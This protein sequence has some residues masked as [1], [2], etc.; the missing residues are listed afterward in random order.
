M[1][2]I[3]EN[4]AVRE[5]G[6]TLD[7]LAR[8]GA[9]RML[10]SALEEEVAAYVE[11][12][13]EARDGEGRRLVV[14]N[15]QARARGIT[16][17][18]GTL[19]VRTPRVNDRRMDEDG[20]RR[21]FTSRILPPYMRRSPKVAEVLPVL[22][23]RGLSTGDFREALAALLGDDAAGLSATNIARLTNEW[24]SEYRAF[25]QAQPRRLRLRVRVGR[26]RALQRP[27]GGRPPL[28]AR[29]DRRAGGRAR[30]S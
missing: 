12:H 1:L 20:E 9:R 4:E 10:M 21:R 6:Y 15:G 18:A 5:E 22:Y 23:L 11:R 28:H 8:E 16:C 7:T 2:K 26:W 3:V 13:A 27:A 25:Q 30:R 17:G 14:R 24:E 19:E 29:D